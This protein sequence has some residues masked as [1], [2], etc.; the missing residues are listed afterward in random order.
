MGSRNH[1]SWTLAAIAIT[2]LLL[3]TLMSTGSV[4]D[5]TRSSVQTPSPYPV[6]Q[7][8]NQPPHPAYAPSAALPYIPATAVAGSQPHRYPNLAAARPAHPSSGSL[9]AGQWSRDTPLG[10]VQMT[11]AGNRIS[12]EVEGKGE[13]SPFDPSLRGEFAVASDGTVFGLIH[14][15]DM[16]LSA[17]ASED[18]GEELMMFSSLSDIPFSMR[19]YAEPDVLAVKQVTFGFPMQ[20]VIATDGEVGELTVYVQSMLTGQ[21]ERS[22]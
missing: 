12:L 21:Y 16:G 1:Y 4:A 13:F 10:K 15:V 6:Q 18:M 5:D 2:G 17:D 22:R 9:P 3:A 19:T 14:S 11:I 8:A 7:A 20:W